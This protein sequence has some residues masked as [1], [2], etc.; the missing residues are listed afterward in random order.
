MLA[1]SYGCKKALGS[2]LA[3]EMGNLGTMTGEIAVNLQNTGKR[4]VT[5]L[6]QERRI[7][8][9]RR[10]KEVY[11]HYYGKRDLHYKNRLI[12]FIQF[13]YVVADM[14]VIAG[15]CCVSRVNATEG[16]KNDLK[17]ISMLFHEG[18]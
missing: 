1:V 8:S 9:Q 14:D 11:S 6:V 15:F 2:A 13:R 17:C 3:A 16:K 12:Q 5:I 18:M 10:S 7:Q 4:F